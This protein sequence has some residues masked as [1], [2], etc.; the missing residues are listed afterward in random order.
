MIANTRGVGKFAPRIELLQSALERAATEVWPN[1]P[2]SDL[3]IAV[4]AGKHAIERGTNLLDAMDIV[5]G[6]LCLCGI[7]DGHRDDLTRQRNI[8]RLTQYRVK[9]TN[10]RQ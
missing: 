10:W 5:H 9:L 7:E 8:E 6:V 1:R 3:E 4:C 2:T